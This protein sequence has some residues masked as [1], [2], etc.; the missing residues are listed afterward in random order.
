MT[1]IWNAM[2][3]DNDRLFCAA[4]AALLEG[5]SFHVDAE[6]ASLGEA[7]GQIR[8]GRHPDL[9]L[10]SLHPANGTLSEDKSA[11]ARIR[12]HLPDCRIVALGSDVGTETMSAA[13]KAGVDGCLHKGMSCKALQQALHLVMFG[14]AVFPSDVAELL[15]GSAPG[16]PRDERRTDAGAAELSRRELEILRCLLAGQS[17][18]VIARNLSITESTVKMHF[19]NVMRK[20]RAQNRTQAAV[21]AIQ[22][23]LAPRLSA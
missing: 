3:V 19:K 20:I 11:I 18:K 22:H 21:W 2:L 17:N 6:C 10:L 12:E 14:E 16:E 23:G 5:G 7:I 8:L 15:V 4:L 1:D 9:I 13:L